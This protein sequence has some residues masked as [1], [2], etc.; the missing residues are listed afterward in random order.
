MSMLKWYNWV[1]ISP[2]SNDSDTRPEV[3]CVSNVRKTSTD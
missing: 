1:L 2:G 3:A